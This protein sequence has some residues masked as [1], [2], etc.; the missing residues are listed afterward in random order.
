MSTR[1][2]PEAAAA[3]RPHY[4]A[5]HLGDLELGTRLAQLGV[6]ERL[7]QRG[8]GR[9]RLLPRLPQG[10]SRGLAY[11]QVPVRE[12]LRQRPFLHALKGAGVSLLVVDEAH[13]VSLWGHDF[14]PEYRQLGRTDMKV[15]A[16]SF[17]AWA[18]GGT[19][20]PV[21]DEESMRALH[22]AVDAGTNF[23]FGSLRTGLLSMV[24]NLWPILL[25]LG[26]MGMGFLLWS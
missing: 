17:G 23:V 20:G 6:V 8:L 4:A 10:R 11:V 1:T 13:C 21:D 15:S 3:A 25:T 22:A 24:P 5:V 26:G 12:R 9:L 7:S 18:I 14:R 19:W 16:I 2:S